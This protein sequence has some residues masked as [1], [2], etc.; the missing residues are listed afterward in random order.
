M[1]NFTQTNES[2]LVPPRNPKRGAN[3]IAKRTQTSTLPLTLERRGATQRVAANHAGFR[4]V[5]ECSL[6]DANVGYIELRA[7]PMECGFPLPGMVAE[8]PD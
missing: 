5:A 8:T 7:A 3:I 2:K 4:K 6:I 1:P